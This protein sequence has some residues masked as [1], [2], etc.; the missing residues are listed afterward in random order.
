MRIT[1]QMLARSAA[2][3][4][5][6]L[7]QNSLLDI[8]RQSESGKSNSLLSA[9]SRTSDSN[10]PLQNISKK[11]NSRLEESAKRLS[12]AASKLNET[13]ENSLFGR[14]EAEGNTQEIVS[15]V[16]EMVSAYNTTLE[17]LKN[18]GSTLNRF[19][20]QELNSYAREKSE[21]LKAAGVTRDKNGSLKIDE[22]VLKSADIESLRAA[23]GSGSGFTEKTGYAAVRTAEN[24]A[25]ENASL[26]SGYDAG[27]R[28]YF[29]SFEANKYNF[30]G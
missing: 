1:N 12:E 15:G 11:E 17:Y 30:W 21:A 23:F 9:L 20:L 5:I 24:A 18:S 3:S 2:K 29:D 25:A 16:E 6:P 4:K 22:E 13:G 10:F 8:W 19:Y 28:V 26:L 27:G 14:A 7:Q